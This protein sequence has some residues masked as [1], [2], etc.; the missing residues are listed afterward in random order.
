[1]PKYRRLFIL[2]D[3]YSLRICPQLAKEIGLNESIIF[4][5]LEYLIA[6]S[7]HEKDGRS[8]TYQSTRKM[9]NDYF[10]WWSIDTINRAIHK[11][12]ERKLI[13]IGNYNQRTYDKTRWFAINFDEADKLVAV[14]VDW[15]A[16]P[17][18]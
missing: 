14:S 9:Q 2:N 3:D 11:L 16:D 6:I 5:Q 18:R 7:G 1:M 10:P 13:V 4:L 12:E 15:Y 8:W 17:V